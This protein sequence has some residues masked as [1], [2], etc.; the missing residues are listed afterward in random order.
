LISNARK[1]QVG[2]EDFFIVKLTYR[3][4]FGGRVLLK[5]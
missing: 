2:K 1:E 3:G 4:P 5:K